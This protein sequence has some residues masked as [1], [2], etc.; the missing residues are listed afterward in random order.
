MPVSYVLNYVILEYGSHVCASHLKRS[1]MTQALRNHAGAKIARMQDMLEARLASPKIAQLLEVHILSPVLYQIA[2]VYDKSNRL[3]DLACIYYR[4]DR[5]KFSVDIRFG[6]NQQLA[7]GT[8]RE[9]NE[10]AAEI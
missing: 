4:A 7:V 6:V 3:I 8:R 10:F 2:Q 1:S 5:Y 9:R